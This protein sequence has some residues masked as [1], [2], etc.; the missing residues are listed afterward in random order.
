MTLRGLDNGFTY[1]HAKGGGATF[2]CNTGFSL[3]GSPAIFCNG[4]L[5][6]ATLPSC[7][8]NPEF[9]K[10]LPVS[11]CPRPPTAVD[12]TRVIFDEL[13]VYACVNQTLPTLGSE[14]LE[15]GLYGQWKNEAVVCASK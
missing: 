5:W 15:C 10:V 7:Q 14:R 3:T 1:Y 8:P 9:M 13:V 11:N 2:E 12:A 6:N 4:S